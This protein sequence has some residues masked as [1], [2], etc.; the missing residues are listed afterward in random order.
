MLTFYKFRVDNGMLL[1]SNVPDPYQTQMRKQGY[2]DEVEAGEG[3]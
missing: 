1:L 3:E 2:T